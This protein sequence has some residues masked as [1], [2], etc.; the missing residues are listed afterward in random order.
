MNSEVEKYEDRVL[1]VKRLNTP[2]KTKDAFYTVAPIDEQS[3][4]TFI[5]ALA[6]EDNRKAFIYKRKNALEET[7]IYHVRVIYYDYSSNMIFTICPDS[8]LSA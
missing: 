4:C 2:N 6:N 3:R 8:R 1:E 7:A 5:E